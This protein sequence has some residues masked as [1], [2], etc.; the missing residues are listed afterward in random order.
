MQAAAR[1]A[2]WIGQR[3][4]PDDERDLLVAAALLHD[5]GYAAPLVASG[6]HP[7]DGASFL[8]RAGAPMRLCALVA[9]HSAAAA[10]ARVRGLT[11]RLADFPDEATD[12]RDA[13]WY[14]DMSVSVTGQSTTFER[15]IAEI[16]RRHAQDSFVV[17]GLDAG[18]LDARTA[19]VERIRRLLRRRTPEP[20][21]VGAERPG[22]W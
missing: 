2:S 17:R 1:R 13:L 20:A 7:L 19:A 22:P 3:L 18:G 11:G 9:N 12:L 14:C 5:I 15:R 6:F 4:L 21:R 16:R 10:T 8:L